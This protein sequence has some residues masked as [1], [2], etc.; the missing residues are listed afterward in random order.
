MSRLL[1]RPGAPDLSEEPRVRP[2]A[3]GA[4]LKDVPAVCEVA[5]AHIGDVIEQ[6]G[7]AAESIVGQM[8]KVDELADGLAGD[9]ARLSGT[10]GRT[11]SELSQATSSND[12]LVER[13]VRYFLYRD[14]QI[15]ELVDEMR[16]LKRHVSQIEEVSKATNILALNAMIEAMRAGD[17]GEGFAVVA[18]E[19]RKLADRSAKAAQ[20]IG[21]SIS[22][23]TTR[24][25]KVLSD[26]SSFERDPG[27]ATTPGA[28]TA[29]TRRLN[30]I[31]NAQ[32]ELSQMVGGVL[33]DTM[34]ALRRV[35]HS[36]AAL[37]AETTGAVGHVQ[38]QDITRQ[39][40]EHVAETIGEVRQGAE[41]VIAYT[42]GTVPE[43]TLRERAVS[44]DNLRDK[45]V[46]SRQ[47]VTHSEH[48][49]ATAAA[50]DDGPV[51]ELF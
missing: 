33:H 27:G 9:V 12:Q 5:A 34:D 40:L 22:D 23:L 21:S 1:R 45:H 2:E 50:A 28:E 36:S 15:H 6:T 16:G 26:D 4:A 14:Q 25:D 42:D 11:E 13:L 51:I 46:M 3:V 38:F 8:I 37:T 47:R 49:G 48:A 39:M 24:L 31:A 35:E 18:D 7:E 19:V 43:A 10:L 20:G 29:M 32:R 17:A 41:D 30:D 44:V